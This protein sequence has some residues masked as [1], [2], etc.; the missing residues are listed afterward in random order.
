MPSIQKT[1]R[2]VQHLEANAKGG[3]VLSQYELY[4]RSL[5]NGAGN[6]GLSGEAER[7]E[8]MLTES[9]AASRFKLDQLKLYEFR[10]Y[11]KLAISFEKD[12]TVI[13]GENGAGKT[14]IVESVA[15]LLTWFASRFIKAN[16][17]GLHV[18]ETDIN[19][20]ASDYAQVAGVFSLNEA[21]PLALSL[22]K[23]KPGW[24]GEVSSELSVTTRLGKLYRWLASDA[25]KQ[26]ELPVLA[27]YSVERSAFSLTSKVPESQIKAHSASRFD[28]YTNVFREQERAHSFVE[29]YV[30]LYN[31]ASAEDSPFKNTMQ[32]VDAAIQAAVP[33]ITGIK[34]ERSR[35]GKAEIMVE[36][37]GHWINFTQLSQ[38]QKTLAAMVGDLALRML[39]INP[40]MQNPLQAHG[41]VLM[42]EI[43]L[44]LHPSLQQRV[45][46]CLMRAFENI[47]WVLTTHSP[48]VL[49]TV[50]KRSIRSITFAN[51]EAWITVP[52]FQ[53]KGVISSTV[54]EQIMGAYA[55]PEVE[56]SAWV[57]EY[58][59]LIQDGQ[60]ENGQGKALRK[61]LL[62]H[63]GAGHPVMQ[64]IDS[65]V[66]LKQLKKRF[67]EKQEGDEGA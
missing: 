40:Q 54:L 36:N 65:L 67:A 1:P 18:L 50:D 42:D 2:A 31:L 26:F 12:L 45:V 4:Q 13:V 22:V 5:R 6:E 46:P 14:S 48:H 47:Q 9:M 63:F 52:E 64:E 66:R 35:S 7:F 27:Y 34:L 41:V 30:E 8:E 32:H 56:Q 3:H 23:Q 17:A 16:N 57:S 58:E 44:H 49:S 29:R 59:Q 43:D 51:G 39:V 20:D 55:V 61:K 10:R 53:T 60:W 11:K 38:G 62:D 37:F 21:T 28:A 15:K 19:I 33:F 24:N 25:S